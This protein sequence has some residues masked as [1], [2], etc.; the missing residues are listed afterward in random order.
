MNS[1]RSEHALNDPTRIKIRTG[2]NISWDGA[3]SKVKRIFNHLKYNHIT[4]DYN[5]ALLELEDGFEFDEFRKSIELAASNDSYVDGSMCLVTGCGNTL[6]SE[7]TPD[8]LRGAE[9]PIFPQDKCKQNYKR[10]SEVTA[11][12]ICAGFDEKGKDGKFSL[13]VL[14]IQLNMMI[15]FVFNH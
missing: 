10:K 4:L 15:I 7:E 5:F 3:R 1:S 6:N 13:I 2:A 12:M 14:R 9:I 11:S 8:I